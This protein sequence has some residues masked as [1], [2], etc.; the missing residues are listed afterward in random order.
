MSKNVFVVHTVLV[1]VVYCRKSRCRINKTRNVLEVD[2]N[3]YLNVNIE[4]YNVVCHTSAH[5]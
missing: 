2:D 4:Y 3:D 5:F 1:N